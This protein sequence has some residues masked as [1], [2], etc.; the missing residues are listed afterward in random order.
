MHITIISSGPVLKTVFSFLPKCDLGFNTKS[1]ISYIIY[2]GFC[3]MKNQTTIGIDKTL[4][5]RLLKF[6]HKLEGK[7]GIR[8]GYSKAIEYLLNIYEEEK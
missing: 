6:I 5:K 1:Y 2:I 8:M 3:D 7:T 4:K